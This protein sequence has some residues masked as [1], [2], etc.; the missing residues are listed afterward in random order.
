M[1]AVDGDAGAFHA[2]EDAARRDLDLAVDVGEPGVGGDLR[3]KPVVQAQAEVGVLGGVRR[4]LVDGD[5]VEADLLNA[6]AA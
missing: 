5:L 6:L 4:G 2:K 1:R 3:I